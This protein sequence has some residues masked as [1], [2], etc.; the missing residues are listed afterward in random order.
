MLLLTGILVLQSF[1]VDPV[2]DKLA[3]TL[4]TKWR[5]AKV[6]SARQLVS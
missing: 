2:P 1:M 4:W 3:V 6:F 5:V